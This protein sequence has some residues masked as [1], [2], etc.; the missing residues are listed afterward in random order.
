MMMRSHFDDGRQETDQ[1]SPPPQSQPLCRDPNIF[2]ICFQCLLCIWI[3]SMLPWQRDSCRLSLPACQACC[4]KTHRQVV[5]LLRTC[6]QTTLKQE[7]VDDNIGPGKLPIKK[8]AQRDQ[9]R[10]MVSQT[11]YYDNY[12][13][14]FKQKQVCVFPPIVWSYL[15]NQLFVKIKQIFAC[16]LDKAVIFW[17]FQS[18]FGIYNTSSNC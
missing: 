6:G 8:T 10:Q 15:H 17:Q 5:C 16:F 11:T 4:S 12:E 3:R 2:S 14:S 18:Y 7:A 13:L 9:N 1:T